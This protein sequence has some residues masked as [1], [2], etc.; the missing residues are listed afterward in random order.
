MTQSQ[1]VLAYLRAHPRATALEIGMGV[2]PW[3]SNP[4]ARI[5]DLRAAGYVIEPQRRTDGKMGFVVVRE[6]LRV[7][8]GVAVEM[9]L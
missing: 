7:T 6:P 9:G 2:H 4:R 8:T 3:V 5:S 1:R